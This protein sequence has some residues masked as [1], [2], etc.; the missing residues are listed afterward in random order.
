MKEGSLFA[1]DPSD[2]ARLD[3]VMQYLEECETAQGTDVDKVAAPLFGEMPFVAS[4]F[5]KKD[6]R[7]HVVEHEVERRTRRVALLA[8]TAAALGA[9][10]RRCCISRR[11]RGCRRCERW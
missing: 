9:E 11:S 2:Q 5:V 4:A 1:A 7:R 8:K 6:V 10:R 3:A